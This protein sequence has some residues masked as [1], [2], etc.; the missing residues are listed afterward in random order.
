MKKWSYFDTMCKYSPCDYIIVSLFNGWGLVMVSSHQLI[1]EG[2]DGLDTFLLE[3]LQSSIESLLLRQQGLNRG[4]VPSIIVRSHLCLL[5]SCSTES[6]ENQS[7]LHARGIDL[8]EQRVI[9]LVQ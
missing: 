1:F 3:S 8:Q 4:K 6:I 5:V 9:Y 7:N 2:S